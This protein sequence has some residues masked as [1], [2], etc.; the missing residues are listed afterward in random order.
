MRDFRRGEAGSRDLIKQR[1]KEMMIGAV[2]ESDA[3]V[4]IAEMFAEGQPSETGPQDNDMPRAFV[5]HR[6]T[7][8]EGAG[9]VKG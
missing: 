3:R 6:A 7:V 8:R 4:R 9:G 1:L 5:R 2:D